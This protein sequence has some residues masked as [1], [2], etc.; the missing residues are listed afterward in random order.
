MF[1]DNKQAIVIVIPVLLLEPKKQSV[2]LNRFSVEKEIILNLFNLVTIRNRDFKS[3][4][5]KRVDETNI[6]N[7]RYEAV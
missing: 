3:R 1:T 5:T 7:T 6:L 4:F 2:M